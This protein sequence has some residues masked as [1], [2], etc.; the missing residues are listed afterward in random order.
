M[1]SGKE[2]ANQFPQQIANI[3]IGVDTS[4]ATA[5]ASNIQAGYTAYSKREKLSGTLQKG[6]TEIQS[7]S[8][9]SSSDLA[10]P[11]VNNVVL[12]GNII[13]GY[14]SGQTLRIGGR[15]QVYFKIVLK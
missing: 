15:A 9:T 10:G 13:T 11:S 14:T 6:Y 8:L 12:N 4:D 1:A 2:L 5:T 3:Q 7:Y